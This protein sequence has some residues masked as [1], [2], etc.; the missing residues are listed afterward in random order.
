MITKAVV[1]EIVS[2]YQVKVRIP[3][4]DKSDSS[5][6]SRNTEDLNIATICSLPNCYI[7]LQVGDIVFVGFEDNTYYKAVVLGH[8]CRNI[9]SETYADLILSSLNVNMSAKLPQDTTIG[10]I[11]TSELSCLQG[12]TENIQKQINDIN[13]KLTILFENM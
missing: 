6:Q 9:E 3:L 10:D 1:E 8:L 11:T 13:S 7:N 5:A 4:F 2:P 12:I